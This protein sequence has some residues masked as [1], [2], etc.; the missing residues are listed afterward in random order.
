MSSEYEI[1][2]LSELS[3]EVIFKAFT[4]AFKDYPF[5]WTKEEVQNG[6]YRRGYNASISFGAFYNKELV[7]FT[8]NGLGAFNGRRTAYDIGTGTIEEHRSKGLA[9]KIFEYSIPFLKAEGVEQYVLEVLEDNE[10]A[11]SV[12]T[13]QGFN[14]S[15][16]FD[17]FRVNVADWNLKTAINYD[18]EFREIDFNYQSQME[19][20]I[21]FNLSWQNNFQ[22]LSKKPSDFKMV[23]AFHQNDLVGYG[24]IEPETGDIPQ[25]AVQRDYRRNG[26][27]STL[28]NELKKINRAPIA[29][30]VNI[31]S[32]QKEIISFI[33]NSGLPRIVSQ[34]EMIKLI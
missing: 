13:K 22:A 8:F 7:S 21:D 4:K 11:I 27:G 23:G 28:L 16:K 25:L 10:K 15:R 1:I 12:Y 6:H 17:C 24:I 29:K 18:I 20:M 31:E 14:V 30:V 34:F 3:F 19:A 2:S 32:N 5:Q 9:S 26:I 33:I